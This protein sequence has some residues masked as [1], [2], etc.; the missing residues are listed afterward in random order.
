MGNSHK[1][2]LAL[3]PTESAPPTTCAPLVWP[4]WGLYTRRGRGAGGR[5]RSRSISDDLGPKRIS[6]AH[7]TA[8]AWSNTN[9]SFRA[10]D[11]PGVPQSLAPSKKQHTSSRSWAAAPAQT[12]RPPL[13]TAGLVNKFSRSNTKR[14]FMRVGKLGDLTY[15]RLRTVSS[16]HPEL[17]LFV[18]RGG[19]TLGNSPQASLA[20]APHRICT[21]NHLGPLCGPGGGCTPSGGRGTGRTWRE[22]AQCTENK[23]RENKPS[24]T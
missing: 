23:K 16:W 21:A 4:K 20:L 10:A 5:V 9:V 3:A 18:A 8:P 24:P 2:S 1:A 11:A 17:V 6:K 19:R 12:S 13:N 14:G 7:S 15:Y 22:H